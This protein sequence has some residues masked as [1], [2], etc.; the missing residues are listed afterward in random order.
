MSK[1]RPINSMCFKGIKEVNSGSINNPNIGIVGSKDSI[2]L[3]NKQDLRI[4][5]AVTISLLLKNTQVIQ[6]N[7]N[8]IRL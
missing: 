5:S 3:K 4:P 2:P 1:P 7:K 8:T 6:T